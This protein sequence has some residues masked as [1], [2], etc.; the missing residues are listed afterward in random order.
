MVILGFTLL[1]CSVCVHAEH[2]MCQSVGTWPVGGDSM[3]WR[4]RHKQLLRLPG[5][6]D[7]T[8]ARCSCI[9]QALGGLCGLFILPATRPLPPHAGQWLLQQQKHSR[10]SCSDC[11]W[12]LHDAHLHPLVPPTHLVAA[13]RRHRRRRRR[14]KLRSARR[15][16]PASTRSLP[17]SRR[18]TRQLRHAVHVVA[19]ARHAKSRWRPECV[20]V[21]RRR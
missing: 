3:C 7:I 13:C 5:A 14:T 10:R 12:P 6:A 4:A 11:S 16:G 18:A 15:P 19:G 9:S 8:L 20:R 17:K 21:D 2:G 1:L